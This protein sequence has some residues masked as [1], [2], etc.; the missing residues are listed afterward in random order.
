MLEQDI[1]LD[2]FLYS[3][4]LYRTHTVRKFILIPWTEWQTRGNS[5]QIILCIKRILGEFRPIHTKSLLSQSPFLFHV[6]KQSCRNDHGQEGMDCHQHGD[7][8]VDG[9]GLVFCMIPTCTKHM[10]IKLIIM[11]FLDLCRKQ[12]QRRNTE[13]TEKCLPLRQAT[14]TWITD[15]RQMDMNPDVQLKRGAKSSWTV[16]SAWAPNYL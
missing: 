9:K 15:R 6:W 2:S 10:Q 13:Q 11:R 12:F 8:R 1:I 7:S 16:S 3:S 4:K 14:I 5:S